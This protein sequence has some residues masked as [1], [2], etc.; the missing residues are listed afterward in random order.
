M[1]E[2]ETDIVQRGLGGI[3]HDEFADAHLRQLAAQLAADAAGGSGDQNDFA[4]KL[5]GDLVHVDIDFGTSQEVFDLDGAHPL[6][7]HAFFVGLA[8]GGGDQCL[9][10][11]FFAILQEAFFFFTGVFV[12]GEEDTLNAVVEDLLLEIVF[13]AERV[14]GKVG[15]ATSRFFSAMDIESHNLVMGAVKQTYLKGNT[16]IANAVNQNPHT[17]FGD[18]TQH[19]L[20]N[21]DKEV[22]DNNHGD[23]GEHTIEQKE[24]YFLTVLPIGMRKENPQNDNHDGSFHKGAAG[25][26]PKLAQSGKTDGIA[27]SAEH[28]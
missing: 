5:S 10:I 21:E 1:L 3:E 26:P 14:D 8:D 18:S 12:S 9:D 2:L 7:E 23:E 11:V 6:M 19:E 22:A 17:F 13:I 28:V 27:I 4:A 25:K 16:L 20:V 15:N 24:E